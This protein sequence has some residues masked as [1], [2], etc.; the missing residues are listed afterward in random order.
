MSD[1][2]E[3]V[4]WRWNKACGNMA[5]VPTQFWNDLKCF[6]ASLFGFAFFISVLP[7]VLLIPIVSGVYCIL[8]KLNHK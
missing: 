1:Y 7:L 4:I 6:L 3:D 2:I 5:G 8:G